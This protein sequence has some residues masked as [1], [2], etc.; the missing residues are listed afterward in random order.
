M[1]DSAVWR[2]SLFCVSQ[3]P[4]NPS[5]CTLTQRST[6]L[7]WCFWSCVSPSWPPWRWPCPWFSSQWVFLHIHRPWN[8][9][10][11]CRCVDRRFLQ[12]FRSAPQSTISSAPLK[13]SAGRV[14]SASPSPCWSASTSSSSSFPPSETF[15]DL[16]VGGTQDV[17]SQLVSF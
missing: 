1:I 2:K 4:L 13:T 16:S 7:T 8:T 5:S 10:K 3:R 17:M 14:T 9:Q 15:L 6:I 12:C 11:R